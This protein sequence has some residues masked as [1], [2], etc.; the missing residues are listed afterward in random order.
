MLGIQLICVGKLK[1]KFY[2]DAA[3]EYA[4]RLGGYCKFSLTELSEERLPEHPSAAQIE[5][6]LAKEGAVVLSKLPKGGAVTALCV[7]GKELSSESL[8]EK[9][10]A[11]AGQGRSQLV[12]LVGSSCGLHPNVKAAADFQLSMSQMTFPH[13]LARVMLLEQIYRA[14]KITE[15]STYHK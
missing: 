12:F 15:G 3:A 10:S 1:E 9:L 2:A 4:K 11:W 14:F 13:H 8:S 5:A 6:A 7:E